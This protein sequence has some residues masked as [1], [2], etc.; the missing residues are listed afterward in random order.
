MAKAND[1][2]SRFAKRHYEAIAEA[3]QEAYGSIDHEGPASDLVRAGINKARGELADAF[4][5]GAFVL[6]G[7]DAQRVI[8]Q[9]A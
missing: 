1:K 8:I 3:M 5:R 2:L 6:T 4:A 9:A 7:R